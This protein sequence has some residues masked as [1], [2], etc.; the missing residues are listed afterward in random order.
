VAALAAIESQWTSQGCTPNFNCLCANPSDGTCY[1]GPG[2]PQNG[3][4]SDS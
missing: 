3:S 4:C 2:G 1:A